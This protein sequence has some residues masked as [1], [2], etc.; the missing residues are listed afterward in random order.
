MA[1][2][3]HTTSG[4]HEEEAIRKSSHNITQAAIVNRFFLERKNYK[5][6]HLLEHS[7]FVSF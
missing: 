2:T 6:T 5:V 7:I 4:S 1:D 3:E